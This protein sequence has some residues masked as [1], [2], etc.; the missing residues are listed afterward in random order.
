MRANTC[1]STRF[2]TRVCAK[3]VRTFCVCV[4]RLSLTCTVYP[5]KSIYVKDCVKVASHKLV[6]RYHE[7]T[8]SFVKGVG[9]AK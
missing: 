3:V 7:F 1:L 4:G 2:L 5:L 9:M 8:I 6:N